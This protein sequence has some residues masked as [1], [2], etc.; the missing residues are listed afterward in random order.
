M[1]GAAWAALLIIGLLAGVRLL[2]IGVAGPIAAALV[3]PG[4]AVSVLMN[5]S[6][7]RGRRAR[8]AEVL[9]L[10]TDLPRWT[11]AIAGVLF[12]AFWLAGITAAGGLGGNA[13]IQNGRYVLNN[14]GSLTV[15]DKATYDNE[16]DHEERFMLGALG[17][18]GVAGAALGGSTVARTASGDK[19][20]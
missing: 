7:S 5:A 12:F 14:H 6:I 16:L 18:F 2:P 8:T 19:N 1:A 13:E 11:L 15:V 9:R 4:F 3:V 20:D 10:F 17:G